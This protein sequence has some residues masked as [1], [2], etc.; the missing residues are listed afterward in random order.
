MASQICARDRSIEIKEQERNA[1]LMRKRQIKGRKHIAPA[2]FAEYL[3]KSDVSENGKVYYG[4]S[5]Q[6]GL[7][8]RHCYI[9]K[10]R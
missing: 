1:V 4:R 2:D 10:S 3:R 7:Y 5:L 9:S 6:N 8:E